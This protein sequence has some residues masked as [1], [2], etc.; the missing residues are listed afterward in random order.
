MRQRHMARWL[1]LGQGFMWPLKVIQEMKPMRNRHPPSPEIWQPG[2][3]LQSSFHKFGHQQMP[4][5]SNNRCVIFLGNM[6]FLQLSC[7]Q[8]KPPI[9]QFVL[10]LVPAHGPAR[11]ES[12]NR[13][14]QQVPTTCKEVTKTK[15]QGLQPTPSNIDNQSTCGKHVTK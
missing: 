13:F 6:F 10:P 7:S 2:H 14:R 15:T 5:L 4:S 8:S 12:R 11:G 1:Q 3:S 9:H